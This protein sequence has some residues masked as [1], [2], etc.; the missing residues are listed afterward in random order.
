MLQS[1]V[2]LKEFLGLSPRP[3]RLTRHEKELAASLLSHLQERQSSL[4]DFL[5]L[6]E[7]HVNP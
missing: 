2:E 5:E 3:R 4:L 7:K 1:I 6:P